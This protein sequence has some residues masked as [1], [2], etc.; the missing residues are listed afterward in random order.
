M[1][2]IPLA[3][4]STETNYAIIKA[5]D[6]SF[7]GCVIQGDSLRILSSSAE[8]IAKHAKERKLAERECL[9]EIE[10]L[11]NS[12]IDRLLHYQQVLR[13]HRIRLPYV[14]ELTTADFVTL[15]PDDPD[16]AHAREPA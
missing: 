5:P 9:C 8:A 13:A 15:L 14:R 12:L 4:Y 7:P 1:E 10:D 16:A 11:T 2:I 6:R 3:V